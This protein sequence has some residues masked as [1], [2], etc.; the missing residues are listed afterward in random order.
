MRKNFCRNQCTK[1][2]SLFLVVF[3]LLSAFSTTAYAYLQTG[4]LIA[5][6]KSIS[7]TWGDRLASPGSII[8]NAWESAVTDWHSASELTFYETQASTNL[9]NSW[10]ET[11]ST[12]FGRY[13]VWYNRYNEVT[14]FTAD[15]NAGNTNI[16]KSNVARST[17]NHE[18][19]HIAG[20]EDLTSGVAVMNVN[21][22]RE[23][24]YTPQPDDKNGIVAIYGY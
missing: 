23:N 10:N 22:N 21:R 18:F 15:I 19:G 12:Y 11:S 20:L 4:W 7:F 8:R 13:H 1:K 16:T 14:S 17:A 2:F 6:F 9:L 24:I 3:L 5:P